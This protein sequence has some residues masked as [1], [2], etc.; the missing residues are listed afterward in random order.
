MSFKIYVINT[1]A[2]MSYNV[3]SVEVVKI[4]FTVMILKYEFG[5]NPLTCTWAPNIYT[6][7]GQRKHKKWIDSG[8]TNILVTPM[9]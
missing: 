1:E 9:D 4:V 5:M 6:P 7:W 3:S 8:F 2:Q